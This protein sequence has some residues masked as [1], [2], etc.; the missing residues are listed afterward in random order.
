[1]LLKKVH[2]TLVAQRM[3]EPGDRI[4]VAVSGGP[5]SLALC[6]LLHRLRHSHKVELIVAHV[7][8]GLRGSEADADASF[9]HDLGNQLELPV[10]V[11][12]L[13]V[14]SWQKKHGGSLQMAA[15]ALRYQWLRQVMAEKGASKLAL[16]HNADDQAEEILLR[17]FR[18]AGQRGLTGMPACSRD[19]VIRPLLECHRNEI[20]A[21]LES[22]GLT[23]R[24]DSSNLRPWCLRNRLRLEL[25]PSLQENFNRKLGATLL[26]TSKIFKA[27]EEFWESL[28]QT[29]LD[30]HSRQNR[31][32]GLQLPIA[33]LLETHPAMQRRLL[34]KVVQHVKGDLKG[35]GFHHTE[36]LKRLCRSPAANSQID[37]PGLLLAEK[38]YD[39]LT[40]TPQHEMTGEFFY[41]IPGSGIH[42]LPLLNHRMEIRFLT[43]EVS[44]QFSPDPGE[45]IMDR[46]RV[47]FPIFLRPSKS[48]DR[49]SPLGLGGTKKV[50]DFFID[51]KVPKSLRGQIPLLCSKDHILW[52]VGLRLDDRVK[53][54]S[55]TKRLLRLRYLEGLE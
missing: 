37:L 20:I 54:T 19:G 9:V 10:V 42:P 2:N 48:G 26:R 36:S 16:G 11:R 43:S 17:L 7:H 40:V 8:H 38:N 4:L 25:L 45:A 39:W 12:Q 18:G 3:L 50:K 21:Y 55:T 29:W 13:N 49:F 31:S 47:S 52:I 6:H 23:F 15:R 1:M 44:P 22:H 53:V 35:F 28:V 30:R 34:R 32:G 5:D 27:E 14:R 41:E 24:Q 46:D 33:P 51:L